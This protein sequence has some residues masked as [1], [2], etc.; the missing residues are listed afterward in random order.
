ML[1]PCLFQAINMTTTNNWSC[2]VQLRVCSLASFG[3]GGSTE[4]VNDD[5]ST[6]SVPSGDTAVPSLL[7]R[8]LVVHC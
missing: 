8:V 1:R 5:F 4:T 2:L 6:T 7:L 3:A